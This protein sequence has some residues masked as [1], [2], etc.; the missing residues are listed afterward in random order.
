MEVVLDPRQAGKHLQQCLADMPC[1]TR[2]YT[3][4]IDTS[5]HGN[6][7]TFI[8]HVHGGLG[9]AHSQIDTAPV[10]TPTRT[11]SRLHDAATQRMAFKKRNHEWHLHLCEACAQGVSRETNERGS[12]LEGLPQVCWRCRDGCGK[13]GWDD[14]PEVPLVHNA[15]HPPPSLQPPRTPH[16][17]FAL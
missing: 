9:T 2:V 7:L 5:M 1:L 4:L 14:L 6:C 12:C 10:R 15:V 16:Q 11:P 13:M 17:A 8:G 3:A